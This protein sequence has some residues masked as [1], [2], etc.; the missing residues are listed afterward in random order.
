MAR[1]L[2]VAG[3]VLSMPA[4]SLAAMPS[5]ASSFDAENPSFLWLGET[6]GQSSSSLLITQFTGNPF[7]HDSVSVVDNVGAVIGGGAAP[8][9]LT[10]NVTWPNEG[11]PVPKGTFSPEFDGWTLAEGFL[12]PGKS[13]GRVALLTTAGDTLTLTA[14]KSGWFYHRALWVDVNGDGKLD[15]LTARATKPILGSAA[16]ELLWLEQPASDPLSGPSL[17]WPEHS[18]LTGDFAPDV[19][20][21]TADLDGDGSFEV[22]Y[23]SFFTGGGFG[24][25]SASDWTDASTVT[26]TVVDKSPGPMFDLKVVDVNGD[27]K[28]DVLA[29]N[30]GNV[31]G[32]QG[33]FAYE[34]PSDLGGA[35]PRHTLASGFMPI[36]WGPGKGAPGSFS[37]FFPQTSTTSGKP[38]IALSG[39]DDQHAYLLTANSTAPTDWGYTNTVLHSCGSTVGQM[40]V[41]DANGDGYTDI[42]VPCYGKG[43]IAVYTYSA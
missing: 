37:A 25:V 35:W 8:K 4:L 34:I 39:D 11:R 6:A 3:L 41:G 36:G 14:P 13:D 28:A 29:T 31:K 27:G 19:F 5:L 20:F 16:G 33:L 24:F 40:A 1:A 42:F 26:N 10:E 2:A 30:N 21:E 23:C 32:K 17:P 9:E 12:V 7:G 38:Y 15:I 43:T 18:L 22:L